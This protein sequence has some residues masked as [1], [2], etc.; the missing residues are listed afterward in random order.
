MNNNELAKKFTKMDIIKFTLPNM[1]MLVFMSL[2]TIIDGMFISRYAGEIALSSTNMYYPVMSLQY[3]IGIMLGT[4]GSAVVAIKLGSGR[5]KE[6]KEN[7]TLITITA[8]IIGALFTIICIPFLR[9]ILSIL[10]TSP[11]QMPHGMAYASN[12]LWFSP[13]MFLQMIFQV[14]FVTAGKPKLGLML[15]V[16]GGLLNVLLDYLFMGVL[17]LGIQGAAIATGIGYSVTAVAGILYFLFYRKGSL[18]FIKT[19]IDKIVL[20]KTCLNGSS[21]MISNCAI[22]VTTFIF[23]IIFMRFWNEEGVAAITI[24]C[25]FQYVFSAI[26]MGFSMG[27]SPVISYKYGAKDNIQLKSI[28]RFS[29][30]FIAVLSVAVYIISLVTISPSLAIFTDRGGEVFRIAKEGFPIYALQFLVMGL[31]IFS[32]ALFTSIGNGLIS[33]II[34]MARTFVFLVASMII[35]PEIMGEL[36]VW[37]SVPLAELLGLFVSAFCVLYKK[38]EYN[39]I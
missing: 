28:V 8:I 2:Y 14:F 39:Y 15:T 17:G 3:G 20:L 36:G 6:A 37:L 31:S 1:V 9:Q 16:L 22:A 11:A 38:K 13:S 21:E 7:F 29:F 4:G 18:Y 33:G 30:G 23:N 12:V 27:V 24:L 32:S 19:G 25:Y 5:T 35:L 34:S 10:G 26:Y